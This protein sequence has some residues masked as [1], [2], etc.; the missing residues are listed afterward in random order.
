VVRDPSLA[1]LLMVALMASLSLACA[2][3]RAWLL[4]A[5]ERERQATARLAIWWSAGAAQ[6]G[7][8]ARPNPGQAAPDALDEQA[9][10]ER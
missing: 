4:L 2:L 7:F 1:D 10:D 8:P 3:I 6:P 9:G 5:V